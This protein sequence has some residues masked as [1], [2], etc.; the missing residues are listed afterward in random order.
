MFSTRLSVPPP[1]PVFG[2]SVTD[3]NAARRQAA[4]E[5]D[6]SDCGLDDSDVHG[7]ME[8]VRSYP[9]L[10]VL[11]LRCGR[12]TRHHVSPCGSLARACFD[13]PCE[14]TMLH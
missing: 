6:V 8:V 10:A 4:E 2:V 5:L 12:H 1:V 14:E 11:D 3:P 7:L 9:C 13:G